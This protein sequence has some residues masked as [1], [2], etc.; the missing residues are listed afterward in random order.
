MSM[1]NSRRA[2]LPFVWQRGA[3]CESRNSTI[4]VAPAHGRCALHG[5][6]HPQPERESVGRFRPPLPQLLHAE[7]AVGEAERRR[8]LHAPRAG[9]ASP[10]L[11]AWAGLETGQAGRTIRE[12]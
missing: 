1:A 6:D 11:I 10:A 9:I 4:A 5:A 3:G 12:P 7:R 2:S 8:A